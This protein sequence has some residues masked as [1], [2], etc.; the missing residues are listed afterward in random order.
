MCTFFTSGLLLLAA[1]AVAAEPPQAAAQAEASPGVVIV[2]AAAITGRIEA[3]PPSSAGRG[4]VFAEDAG[5]RVH[6]AERD[7]T[8]LAELHEGDTD[9]WYVIAGGATVV[10]GGTIVDSSVTGPGEH[11]G[12][13]IRG[14]TEHAVAAGDVVSIRPGVA[15]WVKAVDGRLKYLVVK[16]HAR[17]V[18]AGTPR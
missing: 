9:V 12:P 8:G 7:R 4:G 11:R 1:V 16:V 17:A 2:K 3:T 6:V 15:H 10:T 14:G 18:A 13:S 5:W